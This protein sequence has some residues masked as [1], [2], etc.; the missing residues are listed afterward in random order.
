MRAG[1]EA[2]GQNVYILLSVIFDDLQMLIVGKIRILY[3]LKLKKEY[4][5]QAFFFAEMKITQGFFKQ[6]NL[7]FLK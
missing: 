7:S 5:M 3:F 6:N 4:V 1:V 2:E